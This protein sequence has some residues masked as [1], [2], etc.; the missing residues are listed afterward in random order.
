MKHKL[1]VM[2]D[3][4]CVRHQPPALPIRL[5]HR[6]HGINVQIPLCHSPLDKGQ[7]AP[8]LAVHVK[9]ERGEIASKSRDGGEDLGQGEEGAGEGR[10]GG[11]G[12][13]AVGWEVYGRAAVDAFDRGKCV[14]E[15]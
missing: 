13:K 5:S 14:N 3:A 6:E 7:S 1:T 2:T 15:L 8:P 9:W 10:G 12:A 11:G 4:D